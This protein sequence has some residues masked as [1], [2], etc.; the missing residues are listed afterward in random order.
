MSKPSYYGVFGLFVSILILIFLI[1]ENE[2]SRV[3]IMSGAVLI[4]IVS[5]LE[6][7]LDINI[8]EIPL[9]NERSSFFEGGS[10][11]KSLKIIDEIEGQNKENKREVV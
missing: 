10:R 11:D 4:I 2:Y 9:D 3:V 1:W 8:S 7:L 6:I 5:V